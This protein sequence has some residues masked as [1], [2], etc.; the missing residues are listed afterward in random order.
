[1]SEQAQHI[2][3]MD[4]RLGR[5]MAVTDYRRSHDKMSGVAVVQSASP[6][7]VGIKEATPALEHKLFTES[8][9]LKVAVSKI[10]MHLQEAWRTT[11]FRQIDILYSQEDWDDESTF[12]KGD[13]F[14]TFLRFIV[15]SASNTIPGLAL[16]PN[17]NPVASWRDND[18]R[19]HIEFQ[20][21]DIAN[22]VLSRITARGPEAASWRGPVTNLRR[23]IEAFGCADC[24]GWNKYGEAKEASKFTG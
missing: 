7:D 1:M 5:S 23:F 13:A 11:I 12:V 17:G 3:L 18:R 19:V 4:T 14:Q 20:P 8:V 22:A 16:A 15:F 10:S 24:L 6:S 21:N 2:M 9:K